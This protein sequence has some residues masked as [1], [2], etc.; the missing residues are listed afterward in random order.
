MYRNKA[1]LALGS[2]IGNWKVNFNSCLRELQNIGELKSIGN[3]YISK[4]Y[5]Y[6]DQ[7]DFYNT[8]VEIQMDFDPTQ[9][10]K[11]IHLKKNKLHKNK[12]IKNGP[13]R[14]DIDI[15]FFNMLIINQQNLIIPHP[16]TTNRDFV[17]Y[18][19]CDIA[20]FFEH[21]VEKKNLTK[22]KKEL[23]DVYIKKI[24]KQPK[25]LFVIH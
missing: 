9:L 4:P 24:I 5:G 22:I 17:I 13:R 23:Q 18:P 2:N 6:K 20:P 16:E 19:L 15:I 8:A 1:F 11:K 12:L 21:P 10:I 25:D 14:I 3:I 7:N